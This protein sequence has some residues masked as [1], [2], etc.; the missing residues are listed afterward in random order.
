VRNREDGAV[1]CVAE[2]ERGA[3]EPLLAELKEGPSGAQVEDVQADWA[4][5]GEENGEFRVVS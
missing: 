4:E 3:L 5:P 1:E 2:G